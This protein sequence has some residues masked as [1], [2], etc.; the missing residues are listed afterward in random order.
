MLSLSHVIKG[1]L[2]GAACVLPGISGAA[3]ALSMGIYETIL[4]AV[5]HIFQTPKNSLKTLAPFLVGCLI[6]LT[7]FTYAAE[8]LLSTYPYPFAMT[9]G[10]FLF[11]GV[12]F[13]W[14]ALKASPHQAKQRKSGAALFLFFFFLTLFFSAIQP[15]MHV[16]KALPLRAGT[17]LIT[18]CLGLLYSI[19]MIV[20]G[21]SGSLLLMMFGYY[22]SLIETAKRLFDGIRTLQ[23]AQILPAALI[24]LPFFVG[25]FLG[26]YWLSSC[27]TWLFE[28][29]RFFT[30]SAVLGIIA[31][32]LFTIFHHMG[33]FTLLPT[34]GAMQLL[35]GVLLFLGGSILSFQLGEKA[36]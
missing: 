35:C 19:T 27:I 30:Y 15:P 16:G 10:G 17:L 14:Q 24:L 6:A 33:I 26:G 3:L 23:T 2:I 28:T 1:I 4:G 11:G 9:V 21:V 29:H 25:L 18:F 12:P 13:L 8:Y 20:P 36:E 7:G 34:L 31:S 5:S 22:Y 32:S